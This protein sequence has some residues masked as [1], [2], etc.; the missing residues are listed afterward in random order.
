MMKSQ[1][2]IKFGR[3]QNFE[4]LD[5][6]FYIIDLYYFQLFWLICWCFPWFNICI[7]IHFYWYKISLKVAKWRMKEEGMI[8]KERWRKYEGWRG[9]LQTNKLM[10][11]QTFVIVELLLQLKWTIIVGLLQQHIYWYRKMI[12]TGGHAPTLSLLVQKINLYLWWC[13][14]SISIVINNWSELEE[15]IQHHLYWYKILILDS[16]WQSMIVLDSPWQSMT[17]HGQSVP[18]SATLLKYVFYTKNLYF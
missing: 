16:P 6:Q 7:Y 14:N 10:D 11:K 13:S 12:C 15:M 17:V 5:S 1:T 4:Q 8:K 18:P 9:V 2:M 3:I